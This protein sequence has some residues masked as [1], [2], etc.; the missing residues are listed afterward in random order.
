M[1]VTSWCVLVGAALIA[2][3]G[4]GEDFSKP[5]ADIQQRL[6]NA[7]AAAEKKPDD[8]AA[9]VADET[10]TANTPEVSADSTAA[11]S[12]DTG[13]PANAA[14][15]D[16]GVGHAAAGP[17]TLAENPG[18]Q[19]AT[20][21]EA[22]PDTTPPSEPTSPPADAPV[23]NADDDPVTA[24]GKTGKEIADR[25]KENSKKSAAGNAGGLLGALKGKPAPTKDSPTTPIPN[26]G[27]SVTAPV[28]DF[29]R[30]AVTTEEWEQLVI[31]LT[32]G[33]FV[34]VSP[35]ATRI[36]ASTGEHT[37]QVVSTHVDRMFLPQ[38]AAP[39][40]TTPMVQPLS[41]IRGIINALE[42]TPDG[43]KLLIGT[44][45]GRMLVRTLV[46]A[47]DWDLYA[48]D[49][50]L[51][52]DEHRTTQRIS[53]EA[54]SAI[55]CLPNG[56]V[57]TVDGDGVCALWSSETVIHP[58]VPILEMSP[59]RT[60]QPETGTIE[61]QRSFE[62]SGFQVLS[63]SIAEDGVLGAVVMASEEITIFNTESGE[64]VDTFNA[65]HFADTQPLC[66][67]FLPERSEILVGLADG[68]IFRRAFGEGPDPVAGTNEQEEAVD[69]EAV[70]VP[71]V[72]DKKN[73]PVTSLALGSGTNTLYIGTLN[74]NVLHFDLTSR[75]L[76]R[77]ENLHGGPVVE[78]RF[79]ANGVMSIGDDR[80]ARL[81]DIPVSAVNPDPATVHPFSMPEDT[82]LQ[83]TAADI[84]ETVAAVSTA[85]R[86]STRPVFVTRAPTTA[87]L[88]DTTL[89]GIRP[90]NATLALLEHQL[91]TV[92]DAGQ[93]LE[94]RKK[95]LVEQGRMSAADNLGRE[96]EAPPEAPLQ[97]GEL[98][99]E[100]EYASEPWSR[101]RL[102]VS[103][104]GLLAAG[105]HRPK[106]AA[107]D[108]EARA[109]AIHLWDLSCG[110]VLRRWPQSGDI[111]HL[112]L[113]DSG[114]FVIPTPMI[115]RLSASDGRDL[116]DPDQLFFSSSVAPDRRTMIVGH[117][118]HPGVAGPGLSSI[119]LATGEVKN[120]PEFFECMISAVQHSM[121]GT[122]LY[123]STRERDQS[124][125]LE[126]DPLTLSI[127]SEIHNEKLPG[128]L[129]EDAGKAINQAS[130]AVV[131]APSPGNKTIVTWGHHED[132]PQLRIW[133]KTGNNWS[134]D[135]VTVV[136][137]DDAEL[138]IATTD[139]P[140]AFVNNMDSKVALI[141]RKGIVIMSTK[142]PTSD[143][144]PLA[145]KVLPLPDISSRRPVCQFSPDNQWLVAGDAYGDVW[146]ASLLNLDGKPRKF[147][148][149]AGPISGLAFSADGRYLITA[150]EDNRVKTWRVDGLLKK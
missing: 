142:K 29:G 131:V 5:P 115:G 124:R 18:V 31:Q 39:V 24:S 75:R 54:I 20:S 16:I 97:I 109:Q 126:I 48:R 138:E 114:Q 116:S 146:A 93:R 70:F 26:S 112:N 80:T 148:A 129:A 14:V 9:P 33:F 134:T 4:G 62:V 106:P 17:A 3:C 102:S 119:D 23:A 125:L 40:K 132:G 37:A 64:V 141:T 47:A 25:K 68:R 82:S 44:T 117:F 21:S 150:G 147:S 99:T 149:H 123:V 130:G 55:R 136:K 94:I 22:D 84:R 88:V 2:G 66:V 6:E 103:S 83:V 95:I 38:N 100:F 143:K 122:V 89:T 145:D 43:G 86:K 50:F 101:V 144:K 121:D 35:D 27:G 91:R 8:S 69:Y 58:P 28:T 113:T 74:G 110:T 77:A 71:K 12:E 118:G 41:G 49:L 72:R 133:R 56:K 90:A 98:V 127:R 67:E 128:T 92:T 140:V 105:V 60:A 108:A 104:D 135:N 59:E 34:A 36:A 96:L 120:G 78:F 51:Y 107:S 79:L 81:F 61:P 52:Q 19:P 45:D 57:L 13:E 137:N 85:G 10:S 65:T 30:S 42:L 15:G 53:E 139:R 63:I 1:R 11:A 46:E 73:D 32:R 7:R 76:K 87:A 111:H